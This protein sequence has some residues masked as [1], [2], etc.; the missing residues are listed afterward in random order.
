MIW[1]LE[2]GAFVLLL[3]ALYNGLCQFMHMP[4]FEGCRII[5]LCLGDTDP[6]IPC[7]GSENAADNA[8]SFESPNLK[9][10][11]PFPEQSFER[12]PSLEESKLVRPRAASFISAVIVEKRSLLLVF[13]MDSCT[14][15][16]GV[17]PSP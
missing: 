9:W 17:L 13:P 14:S 7:A 11:T 5:L 16:S 4:V 15:A 3:C 8:V 1:W 10:G 12:G 2:I 6:D